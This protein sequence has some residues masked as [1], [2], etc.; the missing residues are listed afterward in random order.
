MVTARAGLRTVLACLL[1]G[2]AACTVGPDYVRPTV[3]VPEHFKEGVD[4]RTARPAA[5]VSL[6]DDWW[7]SFHDG[8]LDGL[9]DRALNANPSIAQAQAAYRISQAAVRSVAAAYYPTISAGIGASRTGFGSTAPL[10]VGAFPGVRAYNLMSISVGASWEPDLWGSVHRSVEAAQAGAQ[11]S[12]AQ[13]AGVRLSITATLAADYLA[14]RQADCDIT[15]LQQQLDIATRLR[16]MIAGAR[17]QGGASDDDVLG[18]GNVVDAYAA[19]IEALRALREQEEHAVAALLGVSPAAFSLAVQPDYAFTALTL[20]ATLPSQLLER[21][22][23]VVMAER[24]AAAAN[25]RIGVAKAAY[26]PNLTLAAQGSLD[27]ETLARLLSY[28][29][30]VWSLG[31]TVA[32]NL[33]DGGTRGA[34]LDAARAAYDVD[35]AYYRNT[36]IAAF[37]GVEDALS[38]EHHIAEQVAAQARILAANQM[39]YEHARA[40]WQAGAASEQSALEAQLLLL[41]SQQA[42]TDT[43]A[44]WARSSVALIMN[45]GGGW[46]WKPDGGSTPSPVAAA[47]APAGSLP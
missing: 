5:D 43:R 45:L 30:R 9:V 7:H 26:F 21:R 3:D 13:L 40:Q 11:A 18:A 22:Y 27:S 32:A 1:A 31:S 42:Q 19:A 38:S 6:R 25:A 2:L 17:A 15:L 10:A 8:V 41:Q 33:F 23:D 4:W 39:L 46:Q 14:L 24:A 44:A 35:V 12:D 29:N 37:Q 36:A 34:A 20:P 16:D 47:V 28:S